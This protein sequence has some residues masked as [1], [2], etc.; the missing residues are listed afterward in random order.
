MHSL[1]VTF[2]LKKSFVVLIA[3]AMLD[4]A[5]AEITMPTQRQAGDVIYMTGGIAEE[6]EMMRSVAKEYALEIALIQKL[7]EQE[8]FLADVKIKVL[9]AK[10]NVVLETTTDGPYLYANLPEGHYLV[11]AKFNEEVKQQKVLI[12]AKKHQKVVLW[13]PITEPPQPEDTLE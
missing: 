7:N 11:I 12:S 4:T 2:I 9:D 3:L 10:E 6:A 8:E 13:W 1:N 5:I